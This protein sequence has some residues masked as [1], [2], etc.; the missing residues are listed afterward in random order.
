MKNPLENYMTKLGVKNFL[1]LNTEERETYRQ[2]EESLEGRKITDADVSQFLL[3][4]ENETIKKLTGTRLK[5]RDDTFLKM[6]LEFIRSV[7]IF[8]KL[9][10]ME[11]KLMEQN[12][13]NL[14]D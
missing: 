3:A 7:M 6:K 13:N 2:W 14:I 4:Q 10:E 9:P 1:D 5:E 11:K 8:L 12:I